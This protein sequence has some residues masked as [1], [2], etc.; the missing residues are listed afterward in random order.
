MNPQQKKYILK[1]EKGDELSLRHLAKI[2]PLDSVMRPAYEQAVR[3]LMRILR[4]TDGFHNEYDELKGD[5]DE[6]SDLLFWYCGNVIAFN[7]SRGGGKTVSMRSFAQILRRGFVEREGSRRGYSREYRVDNT[8]LTPEDQA[9][10]ERCRFIPLTALEPA[11]LEQ[12][13]NILYVVF[14]RLQKYAERILEEKKGANRYVEAQ[15]NELIRSLHRVL[16]GINGIKRPGTG[17]LEDLS[18]LEDI[19]DGLSLRQHFHNLVQQILD[20]SAD[21]NGSS[22]R[23]LVLLLDDADFKTEKAY[24]VLED[25]RKYLMIPNLVILMSVDKDCLHSV[26]FQDNLK[27]FPDLMKV[28]PKS[29]QEDLSRVTSK[30]ISKLIPPTH[31]IVLPRIDE[32]VRRYGDQLDL[33]YCDTLLESVLPWK[34]GDDWDLQTTILMMVF[35]KTGVLFV[36]PRTYMHNFIPRMLRDLVQLISF[37][38][39]MQ[40]I[41]VLEVK[42]YQSVEE[43]CDALLA[44]VEIAE[45]NL[46]LFIKYIRTNWLDARISNYE[47]RHFLKKLEDTASSNRIRLAYQHLVERYPEYD[48]EEPVYSRAELDALMW[49]IERFH[50][51]EEDFLLIFAIR[52]IFSLK[53]HQEILKIKRETALAYLNLLQKKDPDPYPILTFDFNPDVVY[54]PKDLQLFDTVEEW[55]QKKINL[56][57]GESLDSI[58]HSRRLDSYKMERCIE[59]SGAEWLVSVVDE[60]EEDLFDISDLAIIT[61]ALRLD[62]FECAYQKQNEIAKELVVIRERTVMEQQYAAYRVQ[63]LA[64]TLFA[65][66]DVQMAASKWLV[67]YMPP[68]YA[69]DAKMDAFELWTQ[70]SIGLSNML[71]DINRSKLQNYRPELAEQIWDADSDHIRGAL[72]DKMAPINRGSNSSKDTAVCVQKTEA[73]QGEN[74]TQKVDPKQDPVDD[75]DGISVVE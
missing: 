59:K 50:R 43:Y 22:E 33:H 58:V 26:V 57:Q 46:Q 24:E 74:A 14:S 41:P 40:D 38:E 39:E 25:V 52:T 49:G 55:V 19:S 53:S 16:S 23:Y 68:E 60:A 31:L 30:Y 69:S 5:P 17:P 8:F 36:K 70:L 6:L 4:D 28:S 9:W 75:V 63:E 64:V 51:T 20:L 29:I 42:R 45:A 35:R 61:M 66:C 7:A 72:L 1:V 2:S 3:A 27:K 18:A 73:V 37:L 71:Q 12:E 34:Q 65:N 54:V 47:D 13:Q 21:S 10:L 44:Q 67:E 32:C 15:K 11:F 62:F 48:E 56:A